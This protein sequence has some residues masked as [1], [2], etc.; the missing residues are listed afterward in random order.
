M[1][2]PAD[3]AWTQTSW[4]Q[5]GRPA[6][7]PD[8]DGARGVGW[9]LG[10]AER[11][12]ALRRTAGLCL[13]R[14]ERT[15]ARQAFR[16]A[17]RIGTWGWPRMHADVAASQVG[18][19]TLALR[20]Y[21]LTRVAR[22]SAAARRAALAA[23]DVE[24][25]VG[26]DRL[27]AAAQRL[28]GNYDQCDRTVAAAMQHAAAHDCTLECAH[29]LNLQGW[30]A[31][32][33][34]ILAA[35]RPDAASDLFAQAAK[36]AA[37][38]GRCSALLEA[39]LGLAWS[40]LALGDSG[41]AQQCCD[42]VLAHAQGAEHDERRAGAEVGLAAVAHRRELADEALARYGQALAWATE[43]HIW[44]WV[45]RALVGWGALIWHSGV[46]DRRNHLWDQA[47]AAA[48]LVSPHRR[49]FTEA[50]IALCREDRSMPPR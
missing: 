33:R 7:S 13:E 36:A 45:V 43:Q 27:V 31:Y 39:K 19:A 48:A 8:G 17:V 5:R 40:R 2:E 25:T 46:G 34:A 21:E 29:L 20:D 15:Q 12:R 1:A 38:T 23:G 41:G 37:E 32:D 49:I 44:I 50:T 6:A 11:L 9:W 35:G 30:I 3:D 47:R 22:Y 16:R 42:E 4:E 26:A 10:R 24:L 18:L 28:S 14:G